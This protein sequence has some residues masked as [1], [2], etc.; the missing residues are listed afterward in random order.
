DWHGT[1]HFMTVFRNHFYGDIANTPPKTDQT[2]I[3]QIGAF[4]RF[5]NVIGNVLGR[6]GYYTTYGPSGAIGCGARYI[7]CI[8]HAIASGGPTDANVVATLFRW[9]NYDTVTRSVRFASGEVPSGLA[10]FANPV[11]SSQ[12]LPASLYRASK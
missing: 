12:S 5:F 11:P 9:G 1:T 6:E 3:M 4:S 8:G 7:Y 10:S 2:G